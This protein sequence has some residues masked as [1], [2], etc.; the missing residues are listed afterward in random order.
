MA[1]RRMRK[2]KSL[3]VK[4]VELAVAVPQVV[5]HRVTRAAL[6]G[7]TLSDRDR[8]EF[9]TM[10]NEKQSAFA[11]AWLDMTMQAFRAN[12]ALAILMLRSLFVP[13]SSKF[14][15]A[16]STA[17][18]LQ[19]AAVEVLDKGLA[20]IHRKAMSNARRLSKRKVR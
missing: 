5:A 8:R 3:A 7:P 18:Q 10:I 17:I 12:Q 14:A 16:A 6:A 4:S 11:Q 2:S 13:F 9:Q 15:S 1:T 20:P 19:K